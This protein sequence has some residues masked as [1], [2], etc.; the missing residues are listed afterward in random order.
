ME[1][2]CDDVSEVDQK[3]AMS[4]GMFRKAKIKG[5]MT[6]TKWILAAALILAVGGA[7]ATEPK[8]VKRA[9]KTAAASGEIFCNPQGCRPVQPGCHIEQKVYLGMSS[10]MNMEVCK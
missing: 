2:H 7:S 6:M 9:P 8:K 5:E 4:G 1:V 3:A 10:T